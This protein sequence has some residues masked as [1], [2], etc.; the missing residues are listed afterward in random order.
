V[1]GVPTVVIGE[2]LWWGNDRLQFVESHL[3][4]NSEA[5]I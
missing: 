3:A 4:V 2:H 1:F 5:R